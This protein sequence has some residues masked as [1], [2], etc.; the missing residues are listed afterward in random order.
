M[1]ILKNS[2]HSV[3]PMFGFLDGIAGVSTDAFNSMV[4]PAVFLGFSHQG[5]K[6]GEYFIPS[7]LGVR[8]LMALLGLG[9]F[10]C[11]RIAQIIA[12]YHS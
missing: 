11:P 5:A 2:A 7:C 3:K 8:S 6:A 12:D 9:F 1:I 10:Y 4:N